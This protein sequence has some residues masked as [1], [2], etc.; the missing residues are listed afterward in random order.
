[1]VSVHGIDGYPRHDVLTGLGDDRRERPGG[2]AVGG[3]TQEDRGGAAVSGQVGGIKVV[4]AP[5]RAGRDCEVEV[6]RPEAGVD[7][8]RY[9]AVRAELFRREAEDPVH[10]R[11]RR[12]ESLETHD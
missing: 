3:P 1:Y 7:G 6:V 10:G 12:A 8:D 4:V 9:D 11:E 5:G 2:P